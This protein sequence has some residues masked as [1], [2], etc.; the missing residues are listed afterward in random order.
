M[1]SQP[2]SPVQA[3]RRFKVVLQQPWLV[4]SVGCAFDG[5]L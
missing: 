4:L 5:E 1:S 3:D 2:S